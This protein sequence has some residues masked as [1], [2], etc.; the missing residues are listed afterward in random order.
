MLIPFAHPGL[1]VFIPSPRSVEEGGG[2]CF[3]IQPSH[4]PSGLDFGWQV[5][6]RNQCVW[7]GGGVGPAYPSRKARVSD[8]NSVARA[9]VTYTEETSWES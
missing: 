5:L 8:D 9:S 2:S 4:Y 6:D 3:V 7:V 1:C